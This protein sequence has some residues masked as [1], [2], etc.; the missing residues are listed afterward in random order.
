MRKEYSAGGIVF[1]KR[2]GFLKVIIAKP[3][4]R[5]V[6][7]FPKGLIGDHIKTETKE[8]TALREVAEETGIQAQI[9]YPLKP[10]S[11]Y[12]SWG[13]EKRLKTV[14]YF[15]MQYQTGNIKNHDWEMEKVEWE[16]A[17]KIHNILTYIADK[18]AWQEAQKW[19]QKEGLL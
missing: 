10:V 19:L 6:W 5:N 12:Y 1:K 15:I 16:E 3:T 4:G 18:K 8:E 2:D 14:Y 13:D 17:G 7:V 11:Y 9:L